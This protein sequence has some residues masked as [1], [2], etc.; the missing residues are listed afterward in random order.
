MRIDYRYTDRAGRVQSGEWDG[1]V[2]IAIHEA[3]RYLDAEP[4][5][6][7][8]TWIYLAEETGEMYVADRGEM[9]ELGA[10]IL[11]VGTAGT[12]AY[13]LWCQG[14]GREADPHEVMQLYDVAIGSV[15]SEDISE[16]PDDLAA[17]ISVRVTIEGIPYQVG[18]M[19]G[20]PES[21]WGTV[22]AA[23][24]G[25][26][27]HCDTWQVDSSDLDSLPRWA[28]E[29]VRVSLYEARHRL[30]SEVESLREG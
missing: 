27:P 9:A 11:A 24:C 4:H 25:V 14:A 8:E 7:D 16:T 28:R 20:V 15:L 18:T 30:W 19:V 2:E 23:G 17:Y 3:V 29:A 5:S 13:S 22:V 12:D 26:R 10:A 21:L 1:D 6:N